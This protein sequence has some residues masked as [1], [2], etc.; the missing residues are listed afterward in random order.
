MDRQTLE[1]DLKKF[2]SANFVTVHK[3]S[4]WYGCAGKTAREILSP[5]EYLPGKGKAGNRYLITDVAKLLAA[6]R[7]GNE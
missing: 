2:A 3:F 4:E 1:R 5:L 7:R 6:E